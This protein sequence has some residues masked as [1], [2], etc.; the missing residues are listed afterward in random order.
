MESIDVITA[1]QDTASAITVNTNAEMLAWHLY[2][3]ISASQF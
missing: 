2:C 1:Y 3:E